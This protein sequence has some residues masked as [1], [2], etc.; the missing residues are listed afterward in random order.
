M[1]SFR[2]LAIVFTTFYLLISISAQSF[3]SNNI[4]K[5]PDKMIKGFWS[6]NEIFYYEH[7][8]KQF[9]ILDLE[10]NKQ[11]FQ[12]V[13]TKT[14]FPLKGANYKNVDIFSEYPLSRTS[15]QNWCTD[16]KG[17]LIV[18]GTHGLK[19]GLYKEIDEA[20]GVGAGMYFNWEKDTVELYFLERET[21]K[22]NG[23]V[24]PDFDLSE[25][26]IR[27]FVN[28]NAQVCSHSHIFNCLGAAQ[29]SDDKGDRHYFFKP[30]DFFVS[31]YYSADGKNLNFIRKDGSYVSQERKQA[32][33]FHMVSFKDHDTKETF[34]YSDR[35]ALQEKNWP[36]KLVKNTNKETP[37]FEDI[38]LPPG[39]FIGTDSGLAEA[40]CFSCGCDCYRDLIL[41]HSNNHFYAVVTGFSA[42]NGSQGIY[43]LDSDLSNWTKVANIQGVDDTFHQPAWISP[44]SCKVVWAE[45]DKVG[46]QYKATYKHFDTCKG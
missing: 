44:N 8:Q 33:I 12:K 4:L 21:I 31:A 19:N 45:Y 11:R 20:R 14:L 23:N 32:K 15:P 9:V 27:L 39:P 35:G 36:M 40:K 24:Y 22:E 38:F 46:E 10:T 41:F 6:D 1:L 16:D 7:E 30:N 13:P 43:K 26:K 37:S 5:L 34:Y 42:F 25:C 28:K 18:S 2:A 3:A 17:N 29:F